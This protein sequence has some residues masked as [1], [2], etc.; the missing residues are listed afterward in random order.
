VARG[1]APD[2]PLPPPHLVKRRA[3]V[4]E[5]LHDRLIKGR[6]LVERTIQSQQELDQAWEDR[7][8]WSS[9][10]SELLLRSF[11]N[12]SVADDYNWSPGFGV[13]SMNPSL[14][15]KVDDFRRSLRSRI[16]RL[17]A[18]VERLPLIPE[19]PSIHSASPPSV[20]Q[21]PSRSRS[22]FVVHGHDQAT[23]ESVARFIERL[24]LE[25]V[26][27]HEQPNQG[28]TLIEKFETHS[29]VAYAVVLLTP[30]D[31][32]QGPDATTSRA[33]QNVIFELG[34]FFGTLGRQRVAALYVHGVELP[35]DV[36]GLAY[37]QVDTN[38][39]WKY[40]LAK[41]LAAA[42]LPVDPSRLLQ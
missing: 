42:G 35:T 27:L 16:N 6:E 15:E 3:D 10:N 29:T 21:V 9:Y 33:R 14:G 41:E 31:T 2:E 34:Y 13:V 5:Q 18:I 24:G 32:C 8:R 26:I 39:A 7:E 19:L 17:E 28:R 40:L 20:R 23:R 22:V 1:K 11:N 12:R 25:V 4:D 36:N 37:I 30:D 38:G